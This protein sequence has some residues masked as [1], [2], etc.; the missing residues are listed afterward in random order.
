MDKGQISVEVKNT[1]SF[2]ISC[3]LHN[4]MTEVAGLAPPSFCFPKPASTVQP[5]GTVRIND[6]QIDFNSLPCGNLV[7]KWI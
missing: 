1:A 7:G 2:P 4:A 6:A 5:G 3:I